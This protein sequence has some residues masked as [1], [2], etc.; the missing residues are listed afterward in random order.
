MKQ[1][2]TVDGE[3]VNSETGKLR[4]DQW[5]HQWA[6]T[7]Q[8]PPPPQQEDQVEGGGVREVENTRDETLGNGKLGTSKF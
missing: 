3:P 2:E 7:P 1:W 4:A 6:T 8:Q 5:T